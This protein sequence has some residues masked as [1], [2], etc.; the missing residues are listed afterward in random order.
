MKLKRILL[1]FAL[2]I[3]C[4]AFMLPSDSAVRSEFLSK[5]PNTEIVSTELIF[6]QDCIAVYLVKYKEINNQQI[7]TS[8]FAL[9]RDNLSWKWCDDQTKKMQ[10]MF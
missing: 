6:E 7:L 3:V 2:S 9:K 10:I 4:F 1:I 5:N 8:D